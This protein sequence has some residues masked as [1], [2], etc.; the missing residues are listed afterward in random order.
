MWHLI[1]LLR[2]L[3]GFQEHA[4]PGM[5]SW[6]LQPV[7]AMLNSTYHTQAVNM[8]IAPGK[9]LPTLQSLRPQLPRAL[10]T[11]KDAF[12]LSGCRCH[13]CTSA[14]PLT[15][16]L[17]RPALHRPCMG[18]SAHVHILVRQGSDVQQ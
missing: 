11:H 4:L 16:R 6:T 13:S 10:R 5:L 2:D 7:L 8:Q 18:L 9:C 17:P 15:G 3:W 1:A 12:T 14:T